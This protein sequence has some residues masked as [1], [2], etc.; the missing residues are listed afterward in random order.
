MYHACY[1]SSTQVSFTIKRIPNKMT[2]NISYKLIL[3]LE[4]KSL[5]DLSLYSHKLKTIK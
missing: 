2:S 5:R 3:D 4:K 1:Y